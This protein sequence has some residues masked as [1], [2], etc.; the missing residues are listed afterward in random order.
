MDE[1]DV[2][3]WMNSRLRYATKLIDRRGPSR[4]AGVAAQ[5]E[6]GQAVECHAQSASAVQMALLWPGRGAEQSSRERALAGRAADG[7]IAR[8]RAVIG[9]DYRRTGNRPAFWSADSSPIAV[10]C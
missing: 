5:R 8:G 3:P 2:E 4:A 7:L 1:A 10:H 9:T 6:F